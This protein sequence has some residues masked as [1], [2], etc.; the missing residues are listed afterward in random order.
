MRGKKVTKI[1]D[2]FFASQRIVTLRNKIKSSFLSL[3]D[4]LVT[5]SLNEGECEEK[6][7]QKKSKSEHIPTTPHL[8]AQLIHSLDQKKIYP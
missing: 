7:L 8:P 1:K 3:L 4:L 6:D 5:S 2:F